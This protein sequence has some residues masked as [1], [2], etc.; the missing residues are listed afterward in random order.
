MKELIEW[1]ENYIKSKY[2][3][4][5]TMSL[6]KTNNKI[7]VSLKEKTITY[8]MMLFLNEQVFSEKNTIIVCLNDKKNLDFVLKN[9]K[10]L[11]AMKGLSLIF[12]NLDRN[13][14]WILNPYLHNIIADP[15]SL[16][17]GLKTLFDSANGNL[18]EENIKRKKTKLFEKETD[19]TEEF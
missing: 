15:N 18:V 19:D 11:S 6:K 3:L 8:N 12:V 1:T 10:T 7:E 2:A 5:N 17:T 4:N 9:W 14:K 16:E 13:D